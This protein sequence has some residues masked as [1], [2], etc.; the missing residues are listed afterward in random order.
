MNLKITLATLGWLAISTA[1]TAGG[2]APAE[3]DLINNGSA[4]ALS[5]A[6]L[7]AVGS[8]RVEVTVEGLKVKNFLCSGTLVGERVVLTAKHCADETSPVTFGLGANAFAPD[9]EVEIDAALTQRAQPDVGGY[10]GHGS[11][12]AVFVLKTPFRKTIRPV[13]IAA[14]QLSKTD[15]GKAFGVAGFGIRNANGGH[16]DR[17]Q[18]TLSLTTLK[19]APV[20]L[21][22][23]TVEAF[24]NDRAQ[25]GAYTELAYRNLYEKQLLEGEEGL[26]GTR[27]GEAQA[28]GGDSGSPLLRRTGDGRLSVVGVAS[29][30]VVANQRVN[31]LC[32]HGSVYALMGASAL[33]R[34]E[35]FRA[36]A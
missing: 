16:G 11:D 15:I 35:G 31:Q 19:G 30:A 4:T 1:C 13:R 36:T 8:L 9:E 28:C 6:E 24:L 22:F 21:A 3:S 12:I 33:M 25:D 27:K 14:S 26:F 5:Q 32:E 23:S 18:G 7:S 2:E 34:F 20:K 17:T 29:G 10:S